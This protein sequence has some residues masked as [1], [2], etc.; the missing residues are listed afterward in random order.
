MQL[1]SL[2]GL[3]CWIGQGLATGGVVMDDGESAYA[4]RSGPLQSTARQYGQY[5]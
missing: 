1:E 2:D 3:R 5:R 4:G